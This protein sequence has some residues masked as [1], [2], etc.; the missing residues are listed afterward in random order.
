MEHRPVIPIVNL[1]DS[2][3]VSEFL[4]KINFI[5]VKLFLF[6]VVP[7][8]SPFE[9]PEHVDLR[10]ECSVLNACFF[11]LFL[12]KS[13]SS[14]APFVTVD[15]PGWRLFCQS[16]NRIHDTRSGPIRGCCQHNPINPCHN[17]KNGNLVWE[18]RTRMSGHAETKAALPDVLR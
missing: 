4:S 11:F 5:F 6:F 9:G 12:K 15:P 8:F 13:S 18:Q 1:L 10:P 7:Q 14:Q 2:G 16:H 3:C 17:Y